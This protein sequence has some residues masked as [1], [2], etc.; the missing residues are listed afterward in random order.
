MGIS[1]PLL[2]AKSLSPRKEIKKTQWSRKHRQ[3]T[4]KSSV[5]VSGL[6]FYR[7]YL[8]IFLVKGPS[9]EPEVDWQQPQPGGITY[10][11][12]VFFPFLQMRDGSGRLTVSRK[13]IKSPAT[14]RV[15]TPSP[16]NREIEDLL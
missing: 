13:I 4:E 3:T 15:K 9:Q 5:R 10:C 16:E 14:Y 11:Q 2:V 1:C 12:T 8:E 7:M 6:R